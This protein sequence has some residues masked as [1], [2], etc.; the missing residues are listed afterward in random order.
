MLIRQTITALLGIQL[1]AAS[2]LS[3]QK[4]LSVDIAPFLKKRGAARG[5]LL[6][7]SKGPNAAYLR[8][9]D[10]RAVLTVLVPDATGACTI[11]SLRFACINLNVLSDG[12]ADLDAACTACGMARRGPLVYCSPAASW[13]TGSGTAK[14]VASAFATRRFAG[15]WVDRDGALM[16]H[17]AA[18]P[19]TPATLLAA[20]GIKAFLAATTPRILKRG[21][22]A[23][24]AHVMATGQPLASVR[25]IGATDE[26]PVITIDR[27]LHGFGLP[28]GARHL[29]PAL[30][31]PRLKAFRD[32]AEIEAVPANTNNLFRALMLSL[33]DPEHDNSTLVSD[34]YV[35][36]PQI[37][38]LE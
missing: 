14:A 27:R 24:L 13:P 35:F 23:L 3:E 30:L 18:D 5:C 21:P 9:A 8:R 20:S 19:L 17:D 34:G 1:A 26:Q 16:K 22:K 29:E 6:S 28:A 38:L 10:N 15:G 2:A 25:W 33:L 32:A 37:Y 36:A 4:A 12:A 31:G 11:G 7:T